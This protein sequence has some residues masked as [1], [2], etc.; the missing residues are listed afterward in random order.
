MVDLPRT[1]Y[2]EEYTTSPSAVSKFDING[3]G[4]VTLSEFNE[5]ASAAAGVD[6]GQEDEGSLPNILLGAVG[7]WRNMETES[8]E[9]RVRDLKKM[10][11]FNVYAE[12]V[13]SGSSDSVSDRANTILGTTGAFTPPADQ[14]E[15]PYLLPD[16]WWNSGR[17]KTAEEI[18][19]KTGQ[20]ESVAYIPGQDGTDRR[21]L[22]KKGDEWAALQNFNAKEIYQWRKQAYLSGY[23]KEEPVSWVGPMTTGDATVLAAMMQDANA[24]GITWQDAIKP[25]VEQGARFGRPVT[26]SEIAELAGN[27]SD[28]LKEFQQLNGIK[29]SDDFIARAQRKVVNGEAT[30]A[31]IDKQLRRNRLAVQFPAF[32]DEI[33]EGMNISDLAA[34]YM[35]TASTILEVPGNQIGLDDPLVKKALQYSTQDGNPA[36]KPM[37]EFEQELRQDPRWQYTDNAYTTYANAVTNSLTEMGF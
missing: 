26:D 30:F 31:D 21:L 9:N 35:E 20:A 33:M 37:W 32:K 17:I 34:P 24:S 1:K 14:T 27:V 7:I 12:D 4:K 19:K 25:R 3:D 8:V 11:G 15:N 22:Y 28:Q 18:N 6:I 10:Y 13:E 36:K 29:L 2:G 23:L 16:T 5:A